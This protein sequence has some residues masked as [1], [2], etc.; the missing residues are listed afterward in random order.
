MNLAWERILRMRRGYNPVMFRGRGAI[1][2]VLLTM[3]LGW[4]VASA[5]GQVGVQAP[6]AFWDPLA[7]YSAPKPKFP[8]VLPARVL[9]RVEPEYTPEALA[10]GLQGTVT[11]YVEV[12]AAGN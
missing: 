11:L 10:A 4:L 7:N 2:V 6:R 12:D 9:E 1:G 3:Q 8:L 5:E